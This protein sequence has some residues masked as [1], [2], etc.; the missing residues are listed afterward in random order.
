MDELNFHDKIRAAFQCLGWATEEI[1]RFVQAL[2]DIEK[3]E[4]LQRRCPICQSELRVSKT[5]WAGGG[6]GIAIFKSCVGCDRRFVSKLR[7]GR[8]QLEELPAGQ[9]P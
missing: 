3:E 1:E 7:N 4:D 9:S 6:G 2:G 8:L 5:M